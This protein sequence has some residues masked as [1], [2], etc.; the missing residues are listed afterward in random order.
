MGIERTKEED[1]QNLHWRRLCLE[2]WASNGAV[3][4][5]FIPSLFENVV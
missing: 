3:S 5:V 1:G 4:Y 2:R